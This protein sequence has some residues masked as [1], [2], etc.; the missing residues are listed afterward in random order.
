[1]QADVQAVGDV[2]AVLDAAKRGDLGAL[3][4]LLDEDPA[5]LNYRDKARIARAWGARQ[6]LPAVAVRKTAGT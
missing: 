5:L 1:V 6:D 2:Q 3:T 4:R